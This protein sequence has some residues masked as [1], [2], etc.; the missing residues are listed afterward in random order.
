MKPTKNYQNKFT[1]EMVI[2]VHQLMDELGMGHVMA[3]HCVA[4]AY[5]LIKPESAKPN[6]MDN[7][8]KGY[9]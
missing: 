6:W 8:D 1:K 3:T 7:R 4:A 9:H 5:G 2:E